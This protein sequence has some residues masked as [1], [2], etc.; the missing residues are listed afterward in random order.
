MSPTAEPARQSTGD[1]PAVLVGSQIAP[2]DTSDD[3][4][5]LTRRLASAS[6]SHT[7]ERSK[8]SLE[9]QHRET[10][11]SDP[12]GVVPNSP[13]S[14][15]ALVCTRK[16]PDGKP[17]VYLVDTRAAI[18]ELVRFLVD[19]ADNAGP[20]AP[21]LLYIDIEGV[22]L[23]RQGSVSIIQLYMPPV[24]DVYLVDV[25]VLGS[26]AFDTPAPASASASTCPHTLRSILES[27]AIHKVFYDLRADNDALHAHYRIALPA[28]GAGVHDL[29]LME[30]ATRSPGYDRNNPYVNGL[31]KSIKADAGLTY[32]ER[33]AF[34]AI[35]AR[36]LELF[37][38]DRGGSF[39]VFN[40][41]PMPD[42]VVD[43][44]AGDVVLLRR[45]YA[46]YSR[47]MSKVWESRVEAEVARRIAMGKQPNWCSRNRANAKKPAG[48]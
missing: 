15:S 25:H 32:A 26:D 30:I 7:F 1:L 24:T 4:S 17:D 28:S 37:R 21:S 20:A 47:R 29:Q 6:L 19:R 8:P 5:D 22:D 42:A 2:S 31:A 48:W 43:Y 40:K 41:R 16:G 35:K 23:G 39:E 12:A 34:E 36:G 27:P 11:T 45:L 3:L 13:T 10:V 18:A 44:C 38:P 46:S 14:A 33:L 9:I